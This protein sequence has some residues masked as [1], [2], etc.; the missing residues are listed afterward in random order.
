MNIYIHEGD[1]ELSEYH[2]DFNLLCEGGEEK[3][4][5]DQLVESLV[6]GVE[7]S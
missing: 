6:T 1:N 2:S 3:D 4:K 7:G 5:Q